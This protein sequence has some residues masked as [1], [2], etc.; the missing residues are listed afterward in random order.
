V[1]LLTAVHWQAEPV[2]TPTLPVPLFAGSTAVVEPASLRI[3]ERA[4]GVATVEL[5]TVTAAEPGLTI[6]AAGTVADSC[7]PLRNVV[8]SSVPSH[9]TRDQE[10]KPEPLTLSAKSRP[11][12]NAELGVRLMRDDCGA[13]RTGK[14]T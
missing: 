5:A 13:G 4:D 10:T 9:R 2:E 12:A 14:G 1:A 6:S 11:P 3:E 8:L 7:E